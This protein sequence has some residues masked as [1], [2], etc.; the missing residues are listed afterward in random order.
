MTARSG[1][2]VDISTDAI[3]NEGCAAVGGF[4]DHLN[5]LRQHIG[6]RAQHIRGQLTAGLLG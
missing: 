5:H 2:D 4:G 1:A 3:G 6:I